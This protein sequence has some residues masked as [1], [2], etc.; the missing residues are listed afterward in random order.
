MEMSFESSG[1]EKKFSPQVA[2]QIFVAVSNASHAW[3]IDEQGAFTQ[4]RLQG[5]PGLRHWTGQLA[6]SLVPIWEEGQSTRAGFMFLPKMP[7]PN[8]QID[9][10][11]QIHEEGGDITPKNGRMLAWPVQGGPAVTTGGMNRFTGPRAYP[12]K[13]FFFKAKSGS[14]FLAEAMPGKRYE[15]TI[16]LVYNLASKVTIP[17][18]LGFAAFAREA[19]ARSTKRLQDAKDAAVGEVTT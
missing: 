1:A 18:R 4:A 6:R 15:G 5:R 17:A 16:R 9:N 8:R 12:G 10:Y 2:R 7:G 14:M 11:A 3:A 19:L 13:L